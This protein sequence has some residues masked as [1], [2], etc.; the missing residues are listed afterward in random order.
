MKNGENSELFQ[1]KTVICRIHL[2]SLVGQFKKGPAATGLP[3]GGDAASQLAAQLTSSCLPADSL[4]SAS[5]AHFF[6]ILAGDTPG[7]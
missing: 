4:L 1:R 6:V 7:T 5:S 3:S 2:D